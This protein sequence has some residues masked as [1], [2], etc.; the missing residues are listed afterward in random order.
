MS[1]GPEAA[2]DHELAALLAGAPPLLG[3]DGLPARVGFAPSSTWG[4]PP[5]SNTKEM[6]QLVY[7][8]YLPSL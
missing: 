5:V 1:S 7:S 2:L 8:T 6:M 3:D 4:C